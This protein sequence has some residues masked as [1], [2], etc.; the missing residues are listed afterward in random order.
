LRP[1]QGLR[2]EPSGAEGA[3]AAARSSRAGAALGGD[4]AGEAAPAAVRRGVALSLA[5]FAVLLLR[6]LAIALLAAPVV[7]ALALLLR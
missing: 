6:G 7:I 2:P 1:T 4:A 5:Q 3:G